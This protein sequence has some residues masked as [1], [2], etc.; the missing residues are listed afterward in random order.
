MGSDGGRKEKE[1]YNYILIIFLNLCDSPVL[2]LEV[3]QQ[4][5]TFKDTVMLDNRTRE[6][7]HWVSRQHYRTFTYKMKSEQ[8]CQDWKLNS[9]GKQKRQT[10]TFTF[11][12]SLL[13]WEQWQQTNILHRNWTKIV[14]KNKTNHNSYHDVSDP[15]NISRYVWVHK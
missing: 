3:N 15:Q 9:C 12:S 8:Y 1:G 5:M 2:T 13:Q 6:G 11:F 10:R 7:N 14:L 4:G